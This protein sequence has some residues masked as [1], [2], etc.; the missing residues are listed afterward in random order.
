MLNTHAWFQMGCAWL[1][2]EFA[3]AHD[4][5]R[6]EDRQDFCTSATYYAVVHELVVS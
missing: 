3:K 1:K 4:R 5:L 2:L 6:N